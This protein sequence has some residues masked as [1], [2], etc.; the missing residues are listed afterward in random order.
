MLSDFLTELIV[1]I[2]ASLLLAATGSVLT[3]LYDYLRRY[4]Q[5]KRIKFFFGED[6]L[7]NNGLIVSIPIFHPFTRSNFEKNDIITMTK[8]H[9]ILQEGKM[10]ELDVPMYSDTIVVDDYYAFDEVIDLFVKY[11]IKKDVNFVSDHDLIEENSWDKYPCIIAI[12]APRSNQKINEVMNYSPICKRLFNIEH[13]GDTLDTWELTIFSNSKIL[14][15]NVRKNAGIGII[16][17]VPN[18]IQSSNYFIG[19]FGDRSE[20][21][22]TTCKYLNKKF[23]DIAKRIKREPFIALLSI[24]GFKFSISKL[25]YLA[26]LENEIYRDENEIKDYLTNE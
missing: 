20:T 23:N 24:R 11:N 1:G 12:G 15:L 5:K 2:L 21:T 6:A 13:S 22:L 18:L 3:R 19:L 26:T 16:F 17:R 14:K 10:E 7:K 4:L 25:M 9:V 8:K